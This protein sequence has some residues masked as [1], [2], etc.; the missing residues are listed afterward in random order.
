MFFIIVVASCMVEYDVE[1]N[2]R[3][4]FALTADW[5]WG[6][7]RLCKAVFPLTKDSRQKYRDT[8]AV[9]P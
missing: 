5:S 6:W 7:L 1:A 2:S 8:S 9:A 3:G 4:M